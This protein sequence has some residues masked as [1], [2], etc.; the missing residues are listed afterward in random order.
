MHFALNEKEKDK[1]E[2]LACLVGVVSY[3]KN[4][5]RW[6]SDPF[7]LFAG[8]RACRNRIIIINEYGM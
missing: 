8:K 7:L 3:S 4:S 1:K 6:S 5:E 2:S